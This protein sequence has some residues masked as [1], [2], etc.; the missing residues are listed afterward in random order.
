[1]K[2]ILDELKIKV[3]I[4]IQLYRDKSTM[5]IVNNL[6]RHQANH[7]ENDKHFIKD[8][9]DRPCGYNPCPYRT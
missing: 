9:L 7:I 8:N 1:L 2:I 4:P 3:D 5:S 6:V